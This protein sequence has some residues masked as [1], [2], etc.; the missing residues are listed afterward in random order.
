MMKTQIL[1]FLGLAMRAGKVKTG[2]DVI[3]N[4]LKKRQ[5]KLVILPHDASDNA[6]K[7]M[8]NKCNTYQVPLRFFGQRHELGEAIGKGERVNVGIT[9]NGFSKKL[10]S[11]LDEYSK[12]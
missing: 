10:L 2:E 5:V 11:L 3:V 6:I 4:S 12:E 7:V 1:N 8:K 9:D